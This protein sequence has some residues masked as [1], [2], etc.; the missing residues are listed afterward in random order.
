MDA[1]AI[2]E[3]QH[4]ETVPRETIDAI[5]DAIVDR[6][7]PHKLVLFGSYAA[8]NPT[9]DSDVDLLVV[10]D[11]PLPPHKRAASLYLLFRPMPCS[12]DILVFTPAEVAR[13]LGTVNHVITDAMAT[14]KVMYERE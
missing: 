2:K 14:G 4:G 5:V 10:M 9:P 13:W 11:T 1:I 7:R 6:A 3:Q 8:G 12:I